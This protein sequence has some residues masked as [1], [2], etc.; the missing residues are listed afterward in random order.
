MKAIWSGSIKFGLINIPVKLYPATQE[1]RLN[2]DFL[3]KDDLCRIRNVRICEETG[4]EVPYRDIARG[5]KYNGE[6]IV[7]TEE[8]FRHAGVEKTYLVEII[9]FTQENEI[10]SEYFEKP[11]I[12]EPEDSEKSYALFRE[13][14]R[15]S[16]KAA[17]V[18]FVLK[19][20]EHLGIIKP[21][22]N[23]LILNQVRFEHEIRKDLNLQKPIKQ[24]LTENELEM[25]VRLIEQQSEPFD[26]QKYKDTYIEELKK[27]I[28]TKAKFQKPK[29]KIKKPKATPSAQLDQKLQESIEISLKK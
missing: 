2:F 19:T 24:E 23:L 6:Y 21:Y 20:Q 1:R 11:Y 9:H 25:A 28:S 5:Y 16:A 12:L 15:R 18:R 29:K 4:E 26:P 22:G 27:T 17:L 14:L 7:V 8:D 3:R 10:D 13:A